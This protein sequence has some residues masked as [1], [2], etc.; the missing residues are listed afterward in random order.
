MALTIPHLLRWSL[1]FHSKFYR[2]YTKNLTWHWIF[3]PDYFLLVVCYFKKTYFWLCL[4]VCVCVGGYTREWWFLRGPE[5]SD[6][7]ELELNTHE[8][9]GTSTGRSV[10]VLPKSRK[11]S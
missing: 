10:W 1:I 4:Y 11:C 3:L 9:P 7:P 2:F 8:P 6:L 5:V